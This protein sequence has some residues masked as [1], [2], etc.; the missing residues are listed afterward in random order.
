MGKKEVN[1]FLNIM[2][3]K[4]NDENQSLSY[5]SLLHKR[6]KKNICTR[7]WKLST[8]HLCPNPDIYNLHFLGLK[9]KKPKI[10]IMGLSFL[11][12]KMG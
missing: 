1:S 10:P 11:I 9:K 4:K 3:V 12:C 7:G 2:A 6:V 5:G 8:A